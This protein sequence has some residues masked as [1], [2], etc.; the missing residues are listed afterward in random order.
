MSI[1]TTRTCPFSFT[2]ILLAAY[3]SVDVFVWKHF[4]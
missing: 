2:L 1:L 3:Y 4:F